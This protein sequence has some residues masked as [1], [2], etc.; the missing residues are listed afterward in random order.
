MNENNQ[1]INENEIN[2]TDASLNTDEKKTKEFSL[3]R[4]LFEWFYTIV[5]ALVLAFIIKGF[6]FDIVEVEGP[7]MFPTLVDGD[8]LIVQKIGYK[9]T[10]GDIVIL[11]S[12]YSNRTAYYEKNAASEGKEV[13]WLYKALNY[14]SLPENLKSK[15]YVKRI[16]AS[17]GQTVDI[18]G[19]KVYVDGQLLDEPYYD[20]ITKITDTTVDYPVTVE[21]G[22]VFVMGDNRPQSLDSRSSSLGQVSVDAV[23]GSSIFRI[24]PFNEIGTTD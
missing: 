3:G 11:D 17:E 5:I 20:G 6:L 10:N 8:R 13:N 16:I 12:T 15:Y 1:N 21:E 19:G 18:Q 24:W 4:E 22:Y 14:H 9:P 2:E 23:I 7:S